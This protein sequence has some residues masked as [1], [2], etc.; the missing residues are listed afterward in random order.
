MIRLVL[1]I[2]FSVLTAG[3]AVKVPPVSTYVLTVPATAQATTPPRTRQVLLVNTMTADAGY[4]SDRMIYV[5]APAY[6][7]PYASH[8][9]VAPPAQMFMPLIVERIESKQYFRA[10]VTPPFINA[11]DYRLD[12]RLVVLQQEFMQPVSQV[13]CV[14]EAL[15]TNSHTG[16][17]IASRRFQ[18]VAPAG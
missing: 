11:S 3:C 8:A 10:V 7:R 13:R 15:L 14:V 12:T 4:K 6:L 18:A 5:T 2:I 1:F 16:R 9:W 17:V